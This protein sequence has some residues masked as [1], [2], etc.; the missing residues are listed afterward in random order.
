MLSVLVFLIIALFQGSSDHI[1]KTM[2]HGED[3]TKLTNEFDNNSLE[4]SNPEEDP[5]GNKP[6]NDPN[7]IFV[8]T[9]PYT[10]VK[11]YHDALASKSNIVKDFKKVPLIYMWFNKG[12]GR[13]YVGSAIDGSKRLSAYYQPSILRKKSLIYQ[14]I[15]K[16]GHASFS[17][18]ILEVCGDI[19]TVTKEYLLS[20]EKFYLDWALK[21]YGLAILNMLN[22]PGSSLGYKHT[23]KNLIKMSEI[24]KGEKNPMFGKPKS[25]SFIYEQT[26]DKSGENNPMFGKTHSEETLAK[27]SKMIFAYDVTKNYKLLGVYPTVLCTRIFKI[28]HNTLTKRINNKEIHKNKYFFT[29]DPY[30]SSKD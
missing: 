22:S 21:N 30:N 11:I 17:L 4:D 24:K 8:P 12:T 27:L 1:S 13:V 9:Y 19:S 6:N 20:R 7:E 5:E 29:K 28:S 10:P 14:S 3:N 16:Y 15:L 2:K 26:R 23:K 25:D 18:T